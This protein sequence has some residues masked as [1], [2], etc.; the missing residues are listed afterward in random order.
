MFYRST[1]TTVSSAWHTWVTNSTASSLAIDTGV[2]DSTVIWHGWITNRTNQTA[3]T[4]YLVVPA[5]KVWTVW[6]GQPAVVDAYIKRRE[7]EHARA[8]EEY[9]KELKRRVEAEERAKKLLLENL[10][11]RQRLEF[12]KHGH[13]VVEGKD[14]HRY[15]V[16]QGRSGNIDVVNRDGFIDHRLCVHPVEDVPDF[17]TM[18]AQKLMLEHDETGLVRVANRH[19]SINAQR[20]LPAL[21]H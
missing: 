4:S 6:V 5:A 18:L 16:R 20:V 11:L 2:E 10:S 7:E 19:Q 17:D 1:S 13:F 15:R 8:R 9:A 3:S 14:G 12:E 21:L